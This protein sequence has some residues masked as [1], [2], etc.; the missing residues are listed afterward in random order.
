MSH[1]LTK[2]YA[3]IVFSTKKRFPFL[4]DNTIRDEMHAYLGGVCKTLDSPPIIIGGVADHVHILVLLSKN[5]AVS[6]VIGE[7]KRVSSIWIKT[8]GGILTK[9]HW[10]NGYGAFSIGRS[11]IDTV[12][13]Y[14]QNQQEHHRKRTFQDEY[15]TFLQEFEMEYDEQYVWD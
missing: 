10:Q 6:R 12:R 15:R 7:L 5:H 3:H 2:L 14:I 8:K 9:F 4:S 13:S 1:S 11:E